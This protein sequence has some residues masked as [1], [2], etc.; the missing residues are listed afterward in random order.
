MTAKKSSR[1]PSLRFHKGSGQGF[2]ELNGRRVYL[3]KYSLPETQ[4]KYHR[5]VAEWMTN[6]RR[7]PGDS[8]DI[9]IAE[10]AAR[11]WGYAQEYYRKPDGTP[12]HELAEFRLA[13]RPL[14]ELYGGTKVH[15][16]GPRALKAVRQRLIDR[17]GCRRYVNKHIGR[18]KRMFKWAVAEELVAASVYHG[19]QAISGLKRGH[20]EA[21]EAPPVRPVPDDLVNAVRPHVSRQVWALIQLQLLTAARPGE[22]VVMRPIDIDTSGRIWTYRPQ[23]HK[24]A[25]HGHQR[26]IY[27]GPRGQ[28]VIRPFLTGRQVD[29][30]LFSP[31]EAEAERRAVMHKA[32]KT[33]LAWGNRPGTNRKTTPTRFAGD[34]YSTD[35]YRRAI[36]RGCE[37]AF[38]PP[39]ELKG[40]E[41]KL[42]RKEHRWHPHQLRHNA[43]T[44]LRKEFGLETAR[45]ILGHRSAAVTETYA[46]MDHQKA[47][48]VIG[49]VG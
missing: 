30:Y 10:L 2:V 27:I 3:G 28:E 42:W 12:S 25:H 43:A 29:A 31:R 49:Q 5:V 7:M 48:E 9:T 32:R 22:L 14:K 1:A 35:S 17:G 11:F 8:N 40:D 44:F 23:D 37:Q 24:T 33:P 20:T 18:L 16:F 6:G 13:L 36:V 19:L 21:R 4:Q 39:R 15:E 47:I 45:V 41:L 46:E 26:T 38:P 34:S